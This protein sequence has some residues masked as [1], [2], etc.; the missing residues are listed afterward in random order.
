MVRKTIGGRFAL[1]THI[2]IMINSLLITYG[3]MDRDPAWTCPRVKSAVRDEVPPQGFDRVDILVVVDNSG[4]MEEEQVRLK[5][6][7]ISLVETLLD[8]PEEWDLNPVDNIRIAVVTTDMGMDTEKTFQHCD[9]CL[10]CGDE[11][12][13]QTGVECLEAGQLWTETTPDVVNPHIAEEFACLADVGTGGCGFELQLLAASHAL[14][15]TDQKD[16]LRGDSA[17]LAILVISDESDCSA[18]PGSPFW[19]HSDLDPE[20]EDINLYCAKHQDEI[21]PIEAFAKNFKKKGDDSAELIPGAVLFAAIVGVPMVDEC[22]GSGDGLGGCLELDDMQFTADE[23]RNLMPA[24]ESQTLNSEGEPQTSASPGR[25]F[26]QLAELFEKDGFIYSICNPDWTQAMKA[27]ARRIAEGAGRL[28]YQTGLEWDPES[29]TSR[30]DVI[31]V[32]NDK[33]A[34]PEGMRDLGLVQD[35]D[36][37]KSHRECVIPP[38]KHKKSCDPFEDTFR[39]NAVGWFYCEADYDVMNQD[40]NMC[41]YN[42]ILTE[43]AIDLS[44][45]GGKVMVE[46]LVEAVLPD[47]ACP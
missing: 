13:F 34:C 2:V 35:A 21:H 23:D 3:C 47:N 9:S 22:Q 31:F 5:Q 45:S 38:I 29:R 11:G 42:L 14:A 46:C 37:G 39:N 6:S 20:D 16:F 12:G 27:I 19:N 7:F 15:R 44:R 24:C 10:P 30:C 18:L 41:R 1:N 4:S 36:T 17:L 32:K 33:S 43:A 8:P 25:R 28:C 26:V 40:E